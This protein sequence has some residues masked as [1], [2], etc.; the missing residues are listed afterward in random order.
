M[1]KKKSTGTA[2]TPKTRQ[3]PV[4]IP[5]SFNDAVDGLLAV[6]PKSKKKPT[7]TKSARRPKKNQ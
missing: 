4:K 3:K 1:T 6:V 2:E 7:S 5:L